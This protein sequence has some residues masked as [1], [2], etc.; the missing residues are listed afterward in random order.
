M[1]SIHEVTIDRDEELS[2]EPYLVVRFAWKVDEQRIRGMSFHVMVNDGN[3]SPME[4]ASKVQAWLRDEWTEE[5][6]HDVFDEGQTAI[7]LNLADEKLA[8]R[9]ER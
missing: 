8:E 4:I 9:K 7:R 5:Q 2:H 6:E 1:T 3:L